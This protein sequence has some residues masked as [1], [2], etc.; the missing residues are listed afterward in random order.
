M[1]RKYSQDNV[2]Q[3]SLGDV[4]DYG[5][6]YGG[7]DG[8]VTTV[9]P[10][11]QFWD[12]LEKAKGKMSSIPAASRALS[13]VSNRANLAFVDIS[14]I[15][16][17]LEAQEAI[18]FAEK[19]AFATGGDE[20]IYIVIRPDQPWTAAD[21]EG[22]DNLVH[23]LVQILP[24]EVAHLEGADEGAAVSQQKTV[25][26]EFA[27]ESQ[28]TYDENVMDVGASLN[29]TLKELVKL[30]NE[31][32]ADGRRHTSIEVDNIIASLPATVKNKDAAFRPPIG[33]AEVLDEVVASDK[34][35][36]E[37]DELSEIFDFQFSNTRRSG[38]FRRQD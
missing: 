23:R 30:S 27:E 28:S 31:L 15:P 12:V 8:E 37:I 25:S 4:T 13:H 6:S 16:D 5:Q 20:T 36:F 14:N 7:S 19:G 3:F 32:D 24:H 10:P 22:I 2:S 26:K 21:E 34:D 18:A 1:I 11:G 29:K 35:P 38:A 17:N 9:Q 33:T